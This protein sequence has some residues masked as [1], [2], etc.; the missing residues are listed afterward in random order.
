MEILIS[1]LAFFALV[2]SWFVLPA[3]PKAAVPAEA[4]LPDAMPSAA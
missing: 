3:S 1:M 2:A 4:A